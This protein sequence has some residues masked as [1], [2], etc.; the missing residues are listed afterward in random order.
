[1]INERSGAVYHPSEDLSVDESF[2]LFKGR[3]FF[4]QYIRTK[5]SRFG[6]KLYELCTHNGF[7]LGFIIY[8]GDIE[9]GL[10]NPGG[11][12]GFKQKRFP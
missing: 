4:K 7:L 5:R 6:I 11:T 12:I 8:H 2:I 1:M 9:D 3:I 10:I